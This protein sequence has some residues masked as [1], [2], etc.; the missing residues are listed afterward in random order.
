MNKLFL[1]L[2]P[3]LFFSYSY[4]QIE[5]NSSSEF[6]EEQSFYQKSLFRIC[7]TGKTVTIKLD[8]SEFPENNVGALKDELISYEEKIELVN[9]DEQ[10]SYLV[11]VYNDKMDL[12]E[13]VDLFEK[14]EINHTR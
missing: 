9:L 4:A 1:I 8:V 3:Y 5:Q 14:H 12:E 2:F 10:T 11:F 7:P 6:K 13:L